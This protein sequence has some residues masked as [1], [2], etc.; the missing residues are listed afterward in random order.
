MTRGLAR[1]FPP[2][3]AGLT[4]RVGWVGFRHPLRTRPGVLWPGA[5]SHAPRTAPPRAWGHAHVP[6]N[7]GLTAGLWSYSPLTPCGSF[8]GRQFLG[9][10]WLRDCRRGWGWAGPL[11]VH[12]RMRR[13]G[14]AAGPHTH[15]AVP[16]HSLGSQCNC[17]TKTGPRRTPATQG[18]APRACG[19]QVGTPTSPSEAETSVLWLIG[20]ISYLIG[21]FKIGSW[22]PFKD[23]LFGFLE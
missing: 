19:P 1:G 10:S 3:C 12:V 6:R 13:V 21:F 14:E 16:G 17:E 7:R 5:G 11:P 9:V 20:H 2:R 22:L 23:F 18:A 8:H 15:L 4:P